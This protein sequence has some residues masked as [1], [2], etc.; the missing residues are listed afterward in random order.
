MRVGAYD[1]W[2]GRGVGD[3]AWFEVARLAQGESLDRPGLA[4]VENF[5]DPA[6]RRRKLVRLTARGRVVAERVIKAMQEVLK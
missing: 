1:V 6:W 3:W 4:W 2:V 5:E